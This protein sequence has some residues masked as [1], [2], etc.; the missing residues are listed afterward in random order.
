MKFLRAQEGST[1]Q[2]VYFC[3]GYF[4]TYVITGVTVKYYTKI[5]G[6]ADFEFLVYG[7]GAAI[8]I[9]TLVAFLFKWYRFEPDHKV[10]LL[11]LNIP[12]EYFYLIPSGICTAVVI[13]TTTLMY[14]L[15][16]SVMVAMIIMR[17][18]VIVISRIVDAIQIRQGYLKKK[19]YREEDWGVVFAM[20]AMCINIFWVTGKEFD[21]LK[22]L[23]AVIILGSY[24]VAYAV[25]IYIM[26]Y[27]KNVG[28]RGKK[29]DNKAFFAV[30]QFTSTTTLILVSFIIFHSISWF[31]WDVPQVR[32]F[33]SAFLT[34]NIHWM[35]ASFWGSFFGIVAF[36]SVFIFIFKGRTAT[37]AGLVNRLTSLIAG[38][39]ATLIYWSFFGGKFP[40]I[41]DWLSLLFILVA[42]YF[43]TKA[44]KKRVRELVK[45][46]E[47]EDEVK[48]DNGQTVP[49]PVAVT[50]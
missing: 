12:F 36:F 37:F 21:F 8:C 46:H 15:P 7:T 16:I 24:V 49:M 9:P 28:A 30:E 29:F 13:P 35:S 43:I 31:G 17:A 26:N 5:V 20:V 2:L 3:I 14:S 44:E 33:R 6:M 38:T 39:A 18:S 40:D 50:E 19:V 25:R 42:I 34:P 47:V 1:K 45:T 48:S 27:Y 22:S 11:G 10:R 41:K 32:A 23:P 4:V